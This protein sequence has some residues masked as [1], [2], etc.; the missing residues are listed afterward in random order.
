M[1][2]T[3]VGELLLPVLE[4]LESADHL[5]SPAYDPP[6]ESPIEDAFAWHAV[7][8]LSRDAVFDKQVD[9]LTRWGLFRLDFV[10]RT[11]SRVIGVECDGRDYH[12]IWRD[13]MR[14]AL[15][16][17]A[18]VVDV[19][20]RFPGSAIFHSPEACLYCLALCEPAAFD[21]RGLI[22]L[23]LLTSPWTRHYFE[24]TRTSSGFQIMVPFDERYS[25][26]TVHRHH[27]DTSG[28]ARNELRAFFE[29]ALVRPERSLDALIAARGLASPASWNSA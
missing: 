13:Q 5:R 6:Y 3:R 2:W 22:N 10:I 28:N 18:G 25:R 16:L 23:H 21:D 9:A 14:D 24:E 7:K 20:Y 12:D 11:G 15:I 26:N 29:W 19:V 8:H 27:L 4:A 1:A 17:G